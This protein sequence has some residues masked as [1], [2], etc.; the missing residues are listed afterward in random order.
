MEEEPPMQEKNPQPIIRVSDLHKKFGRLEVLR[1]LDLE[2]PERQVVS[3]IGP[4][5]SGKST[6][7]RIL[8]TL[9]R[10][11]RGRV[12]IDGESYFTQNVN[13]V[14][15]PATPAHIRRI[16]QQ[17]GMVFQHFNLFPHMT[18]LGNVMEAPM[19]VT[20]LSRAE[21]EEQA[22]KYLDDVGLGEKALEYPA[23]LSGGQKQRVAIARALAMHPRIML[24]DEITSALDPE[25]VGGILDLL[26]RLADRGETTMLIVTHEMRFARESSDRVLFFDEGVILEDG[27]PEAI[28]NDPSHERTQRFLRDVRV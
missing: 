19:R 25:L 27:N 11:T 23:R 28:F 6:L 12:V 5:G 7:L 20:G 15:R 9:E 10:P 3:I 24:F 16:R 8:M 13:G 4:S 1:G 18:A 2:I 22:R 26:R 17:I 14:E 21:A